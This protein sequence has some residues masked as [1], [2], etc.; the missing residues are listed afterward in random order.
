MIRKSV[1]Q[2][3]V[4]DLQYS[5]NADGFLLQQEMSDWCN[6]ELAPG[7]EDVIDK[8]DNS[9]LV[10]KIERIE[11]EITVGE[12]KDW[13]NQL[14]K[15]IALQLQEKLSNLSPA[16]DNKITEETIGQH[17]FDLFIYYL[18]NGYLPWWS[19]IRDHPG[20][21]VAINGWLREGV[22]TVMKVRLLKILSSSTVT[23]RI[24]DEL[25]DD[26]FLKLTALY[27]KE[28]KPALKSLF[29]DV[30][31]LSGTIEMNK[32]KEVLTVFKKMVWQHADNADPFRAL[33]Q[34][35]INFIHRTAYHF[36]ND[37]HLV[38][39]KLSTLSPIMKEIILLAEKELGQSVGAEKTDTIL[40]EPMAP[41]GSEP[42]IKMAEENR[43]EKPEEA[44]YIGNSGLVLIA[45]FL[46][47]LFTKLK[48]SS[49][50]KLPDRDIAVNLVNYLATGKEHAA[51]F[52]LVMAKILCGLDPGTPVRTI[53][54]FKE[55]Y[56][57]EA[58]DLLQSIIGHWQ[59]LKD[60]SVEAL[61]ETFL[62]R[63]G[64][65][66]FENGEWLLQVEQKPYDM[67]LQSIPWSIGMIKLPW[68]KNMLKTEWG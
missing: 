31:R 34:V 23:Q 65:L 29:R 53:I 57:I 52:E 20:F 10:K 21:S 35:V 28:Q 24:A 63:D 11:L 30:V 40:N 17:F 14:S 60:T 42:E 56:K 62:Q 59:V 41:T 58:E 37:K 39:S 5:G 19:T 45:A 9:S 22:T 2:Q 16:P 15:Q 33:Q 44:I 51:G 25:T 46:P 6:R 61:R 12:Q 13:L 49:G 67:L 7:L 38:L 4:I 18:K 66:S 3:T 68:M 50:D 26:Q 27:Y 55:E 36:D 32:R 54:N 64:K 43:E 8:S 47:A 1:I 48:L